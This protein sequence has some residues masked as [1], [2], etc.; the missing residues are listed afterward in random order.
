[1]DILLLLSLSNDVE[2][3]S[4]P[5]ETGFFTFM[6]WNLNSLAKDNFQRV[7]SIEAYNSLF[8]YDIISLCETTL[9][10]SIEI[11]DPLLDDYTFISA[12]NL[13]NAR[14]G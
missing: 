2:L 7:H 11:P 5:F 9:N 13:F 3:N 1:M 8:N 4:G 12:N 10:D 6:N 14:H